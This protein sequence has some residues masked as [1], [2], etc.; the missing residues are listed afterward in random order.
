MRVPGRNLSCLAI[1]LVCSMLALCV[2]GC[3]RKPLPPPTPE[4]QA[5]MQQRLLSEVNQTLL[6][7]ENE[8]ANSQTNQALARVEA[9][10]QEQRFA[11]YRAQIFDG[12]LRLMLRSGDDAPV[13]RRI[14]ECC[15]DVDL[16][17][18]GTGLLYRYYH[19]RNDLTNAAAW[20]AT[21][22]AQT[23]LVAALQRVAYTWNVDENTALSRDDQVLTALQQATTTLPQ[24]DSIPLLVH[25][26]EG[27]FAAGRPDT[28]ERI[29][30]LAAAEQPQSDALAHL[31]TI[32]RVRLHAARAQWDLLPAAFASAVGSLP[33]PDLERLMRSVFPVIQKADK[34]NLI[35]QCAEAVVAAGAAHTNT[36]AG[37]VSTAARVLVENVM[38]T[39]KAALPARL[40]SLLQARVPVRLVT[41]FYTRFFYTFTESPAALKDLLVIGERLVPMAEDEETR[42]ELKTKLLDGCFLLHDYDQALVM[43]ESGIP[44]RDAAWHQTAIIKV[45][46]HRAL[47]HQNPREAVKYFREFMTFMQNSKEADI[48]DPVSG[49]AYTKEMILG[50]NAK[51][52][53]DI[54]AGIPDAAEA[55]KAYDEARGLY[56]QALDKTR[57]AD[58]RKVIEGEMAQLPK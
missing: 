36:L 24:T 8:Y 42:A 55:A 58:A 48:A 39:D 6:S 35:D 27:L 47:E 30:T 23:N 18:V 50:R 49:T 28:V 34:R 20:S 52:I 43:L 17:N 41:D 56:S 45:K 19:D 7:A 40:D 3:R 9:A 16:A 37:S 53:G 12:L 44:G 11:P 38:A 22:M 29:L 46:A 31:V 2:A 4:E 57:D 15:G 32:T 26:I 21:L 51:R 14:L 54:L 33:D 25:A 1:L 10:L 5:A 13:R